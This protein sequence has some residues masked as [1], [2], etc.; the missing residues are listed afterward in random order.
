VFSDGP[1]GAEKTAHGGGATWNIDASA[2]E[3]P[4]LIQFYNGSYVQM[5]DWTSITYDAG[6]DEYDVLWPA[7]RTG[8]SIG[9]Y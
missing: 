8:F 9:I 1:N 2:G 7:S 6:D 4:W 3:K 5:T